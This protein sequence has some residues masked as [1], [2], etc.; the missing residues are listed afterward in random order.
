MEQKII[1]HDPRR[2]CPLNSKA[3]GDNQ[4]T[5]LDK[6]SFE[7][8]IGNCKLDGEKCHHETCETF[9]RIFSR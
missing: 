3:R 8:E 5:I 6:D 1:E 2:Y 9:Q 7:H 4:L